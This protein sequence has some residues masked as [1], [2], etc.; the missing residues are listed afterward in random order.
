MLYFHFVFAIVLWEFCALKAECRETCICLS[1]EID[2]LRNPI[3]IEPAKNEGENVYFIGEQIGIIYLYNPKQSLGNKL[4]A[5]IN[6]S[7]RIVLEKNAHDE[8]GLLGFAVHPMFERNRKIYLYSVRTLNE[9]QFAVISEITSGD[10]G[11]ERQLLFIEQPGDIRNGG[12]LLFGNTD[13]YL[14]IFVGDGGP[15]HTKDIQAQ[16]T[17][18]LLGKVLRVNVD[19]TEVIDN[20]L[21]FY[22]IPHDNPKHAEWRPEVFSVGFRNSWRCSQDAGKPSGEGKGRIFCGELGGDIADEVNIIEKGGNYGWPVKEGNTCTNVSAKC[23]TL[24]NERTPVLSIP[25]SDKG[26]QALVGGPLYRGRD[27]TSLDG[28]LILG[29]VFGGSLFTVGEVNGQWKTEPLPF[30]D[31]GTCSCTAREHMSSVLLSFGQ[32]HEGEVL[33]LM[34]DDVSIHPGSDR[35][36]VLRMHAPAL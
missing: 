8:R 12:Q 30:C 13:G 16:N 19:A 11:T 1:Q 31:K 4:T 25:H 33:L 17:S 27:V 26:M 7:D 32:T 5:Y 35:G 3:H 6:V 34:T 2:G 15:I 9:R 10:V 28:K 29:D 24:D 18:S 22:V 14:Y 21:Q 36:R 20:K 23:D